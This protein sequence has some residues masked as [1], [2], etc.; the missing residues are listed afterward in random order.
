MEHKR[1]ARLVFV[2]NAK[3]DLIR[4]QL[5]NGFGSNEF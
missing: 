4:F 3:I 1:V 2:N 5:T